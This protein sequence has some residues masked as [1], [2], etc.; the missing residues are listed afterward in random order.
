MALGEPSPLLRPYVQGMYTGSV[1][2]LTG[3]LRRLEVP[4][5]GVVCIF[6]FGDGY[7]VIDPREARPADAPHLGS[8]VAGLYDAWV[9]VEASGISRCV[10]VN[11]TP[12]GATRLFGHPMRDVANRTVPMEA[13]LGP[14]ALLLTERMREAPTWEA[15]FAVLESALLARLARARG[16]PALVDAAWHALHAAGGAVD[17]ATLARSLGC[18]RRYLTEQLREY[19]GLPPKLLARLIR[20]D[21]AVARLAR[22]AS[23]T[24]R[25]CAPR[26]SALAHHAG[27]YD[28]AHM[29]RDFRAFA[30]MSPSAYL[31]MCH[32][33]FGALI[34]GD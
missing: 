19:V 16:L 9:H 23:A 18:S 34:V 12:L 1:E 29:D 24:T 11:L 6:D 31:A 2:R 25:E 14:A 28:H 20:F 27:Y 30:G 7:R 26:L 22:S 8:F 4:H 32:P 15:R 13:L 17:V 5:P 3:M 33:T 10:Q 21:R